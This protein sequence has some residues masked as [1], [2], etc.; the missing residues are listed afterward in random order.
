[1]IGKLAHVAIAVPDL[2]SAI[3]QYETIFG[4]FVS[5][6]EDLSS[7]GIRLA[8]VKL[9]NTTIELITPL[10]KNSPLNNFLKRHPE[11]GIHHLCYEVSNLTKAR[12]EL[13]AA[14]LRV[15][16]DGNPTPGYHGNPVLFFNP[17]DCLGALVELEEVA[18]SIVKD[19]LESHPQKVVHKTPQKN[20]ESFDG[21]E[22]IGIDIEVDFKNKTPEDNGERG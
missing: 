19:T 3:H 17:K 6:P 13:I 12:D 1:M 22:G 20:A 11:G 7:H 8:I 5:S 2:R 9:A 10:D 21:I 16:G 15:I 14:G 4:A 18:P